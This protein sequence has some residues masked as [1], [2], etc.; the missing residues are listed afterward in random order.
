MT[1]TLRVLV[2]GAAL[3]VSALAATSPSHAFTFAKQYSPGIS[4]MR[5]TACSWQ[6]VFIAGLLNYRNTCTGEVRPALR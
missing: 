5:Q 3:A 1:T 4:T 2:A 6:P